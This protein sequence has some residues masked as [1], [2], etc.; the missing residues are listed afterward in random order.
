M[1]TVPLMTFLE[2]MHA[3][4]PNLKGYDETRLFSVLMEAGFDVE[5]G[6]EADGTTAVTHPEIT[7][8]VEKKLAKV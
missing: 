1:P 5:F 7:G 6:I 4:F 2:T 3:R 8:E